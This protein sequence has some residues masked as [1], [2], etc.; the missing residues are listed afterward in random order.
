MCPVLV[1]CSPPDNMLFIVPSLK[2]ASLCHPRVHSVWQAL[3]DILF[4]DLEKVTKNPVSCHSSEKAKKSQKRK[5]PEK[6]IAK[7]LA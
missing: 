6:N 5:C 4:V 1:N 3:L 2:E 7:R